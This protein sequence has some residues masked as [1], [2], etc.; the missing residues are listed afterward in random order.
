MLN[1]I[2]YIYSLHCFT[3]NVIDKIFFFQELLYQDAEK[4]GR[5]CST[6]EAKGIRTI[7]LSIGISNYILLFTSL[8]KL[9]VILWIVD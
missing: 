4:G 3:K 8:F 2:D 5:F 7:T 6:R 1:R 9:V